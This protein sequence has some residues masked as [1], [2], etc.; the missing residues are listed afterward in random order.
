MDRTSGKK[1]NAE[2]LSSQRD[3]EIGFAGGGLYPRR[4]VSPRPFP[5]VKFAQHEA[6]SV[7]AKFG[8]C[9]PL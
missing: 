7:R 5:Q 1:D 8:L 3:A 6:N 2:T 4:P 9:R